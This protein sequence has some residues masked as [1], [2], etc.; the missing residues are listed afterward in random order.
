MAITK[1]L[2]KKLE[3]LQIEVP[4]SRWTPSQL[5]A[6]PEQLL[7]ATVGQLRFLKEELLSMQ[8]RNDVQREQLGKLWAEAAVL[9]A[10][11]AALQE[12]KAAH[13]SE[14]SL[15]K[16]LQHWGDAS[17][18]L[19]SQLEVVLTIQ[20][21]TQ[22]KGKRVHA[23]LRKK[24]QQKE[25]EGCGGMMPLGYMH[26]KELL[27]MMQPRGLQEWQVHFELES[28]HAETVDGAL[29]QMAREG[30]SKKEEKSDE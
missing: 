8:K 16:I 3:E 17:P 21:A 2:L 4:G 24:G 28:F 13:S 12:L 14:E 10:E 18:Q 11:V 5:A 27:S 22:K 1:K 19:S 15:V 6:F 26:P 25:W 29:S 7:S 9:Q 23:M 20:L 30:A